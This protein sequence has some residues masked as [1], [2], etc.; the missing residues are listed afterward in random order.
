MTFCPI[1]SGKEYSEKNHGESEVYRM[2]G[3]FGLIK[4]E[5]FGIPQAQN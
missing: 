3:G 5:N 1:C 2:Y 4:K